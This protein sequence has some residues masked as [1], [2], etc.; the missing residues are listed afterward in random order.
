[1]IFVAIASGIISIHLHYGSHVG[2]QE[3]ALQP[4]FPYNIIE[5]FPTSFACNSLFVGSNDFK[6]DTKTCFIVLLAVSKFGA[7]RS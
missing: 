7:N 1:M 6:Y 5:N 3:N 4:I 2:G